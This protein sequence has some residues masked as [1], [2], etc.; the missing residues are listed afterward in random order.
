[1]LFWNTCSFVI[2]YSSLKSPFGSKNNYIFQQSVQ[3][4][5]NINP[6]GIVWNAHPYHGA[7]YCNDMIL[8]SFTLR[9][10]AACT[11]INFI[12]RWWDVIQL[13][14]LSAVPPVFEIVIKLK[15]TISLVFSERYVYCVQTWLLLTSETRHW[16]MLW[17]GEQYL[18]GIAG[19]IS[20]KQ[21]TGSS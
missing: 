1:M 19:S 11:N 7:V 13:G 8:L 15:Y 18:G 2:A 16:C 9:F 10:Y 3:L 4:N 21:G 5:Y 17:V 14:Y 6:H 20:R 12:S